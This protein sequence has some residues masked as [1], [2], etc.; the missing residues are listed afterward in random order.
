MIGQTISHYTILEKL[1]EGG[2]GVVYKAHDTKLDRDVALKFL[3]PSLTVSEQ[4]RARF[5]QEAKASAILSH[6]NICPIHAIEEHQ[7]QLFI[8]MDLIDGQTLNEKKQSFSLKQ[9]V[10]ISIQ[11]AEGL[12]S[13]HERGIVHRD[14]KPENIM[15]RKDGIVQIMDFGLAKLRGAS[16]LTKE[17]TTV[18]TL[19]Y[20]SPEQVEGRDIDHRSDIFSL[21]ILMYELFTGQLPFKG[22]H[23]AAILYE[24]VNVDPQPMSSIKPEIDPE[25]DRIVFECLAKDADERCQAAKDISRDL[26]RFKRESSRQRASRTIAT[27]VSPRTS[28]RSSS[29]VVSRLR[30]ILFSLGWVVALGLVV[31]LILSRIEEPKSMGVHRWDLNLPDSRPMAFV[32]ASSLGL[33]FTA[34]ALSPD[35]SKLVYVAWSGAKTEL[36]LRDLSKLD[37]IPLAGTLGAY[38][39][40][41]SPDGKWIGFISAGELKKIQ[42]SGGPVIVLARVSEPYGAVWPIAERL[43]I[44]DHQGRNLSWVPAT[45]GTPLPF[46]DG[47]AGSFGCPQVLPGGRWVLYSNTGRQ[48]RLLSL[49]TKTVSVLTREGVLPLAASDSADAILGSSPQYVAS[50]HLLYSASGSNGVL[51]AIPFDPSTPKILGL[52]SP[53]LSGIR[54]EGDPAGGQ[55]A[56]ASD[57]TLIYALGGNASLTEFVRINPNGSRDTLPI[58]RA[59]YGEFKISPDGRRILTRVWPEASAPEHRILD[60]DRRDQMKVPA[61]VFGYSCD[62]LPDG[63]NIVLTQSMRNKPGQYLILRNGLSDAKTGDTLAVGNFIAHRS[64]RN[65][66]VLSGSVRGPRRGIG[67]MNTATGV[68]SLLLEDSTASFPIPS[69]DGRWMAYTSGQS[70]QSEVWV[71]KLTSPDERYKISTLGGEEPVW[72]AKGDELFYRNAKE[73]MAVPVSTGAKVV[74]GQPILLFKG[75]YYNNPGW[76]HDVFP[77]GSH[78]VLLGS[79]VDRTNQLL[80][81]T[82]F[83]EEIK[84]L[85]PVT[86]K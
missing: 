79:D 57:G 39:P 14:I 76:S 40:V 23:E 70:G 44:A 33:G 54:Q 50:G 2:M 9:V 78:L 25:L 26:R 5:I 65:G 13:A 31:L 22:V 24:I 28:G 56:L 68:T 71:V 47:S 17:G 60:L 43:L 55:F 85:A 67:F 12:A 1:G 83:F 34:L 86:S 69:P 59:D 27:A 75:P 18:G 41:F 82:N 77:D 35:G 51:M 45:G 48:I 29:T 16:K 7:G 20:M 10:E 8:V 19:S 15:I 11:I 62:W 66:S 63:K 37:A 21:G 84:R 74:R 30:S 4:D 80:V 52:P 32:G 53:I 81:V 46:S 73:W 42:V 49:E 6:P 72:S 61:R 36:Y 58:P 3:P 64:S 38:N